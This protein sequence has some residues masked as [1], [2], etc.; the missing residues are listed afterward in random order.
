MNRET[1][2]KIP[3][4]IIGFTTGIIYHRLIDSYIL[5]AIFALLTTLVLSMII[6]TISKTYKK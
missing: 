4:I 3:Y 6:Y 1:L 2:R 5:G